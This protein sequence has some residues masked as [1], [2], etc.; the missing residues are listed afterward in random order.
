MAKQQAIQ[1]ADAQIAD[2][3]IGAIISRE[4]AAVARDV[5]ALEKRAAKSQDKSAK[6]GRRSKDG[7]EGLHEVEI[8]PRE[9][10]A[11]AVLQ[12]HANRLRQVQALLADDPELVR[13]VDVSI[14]NRVGAAQRKQAV[15]SVALAILSLIA[16]WLLSAVTPLSA[17]QLFAR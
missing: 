6:A 10:A 7:D 2:S 14:R 17:A 1:T 15:I 16:G 3:A 5:K 4:L 8:L 11:I 13:V 9:L 12:D